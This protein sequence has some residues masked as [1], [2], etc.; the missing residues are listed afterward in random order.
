M[1]LFMKGDFTLN[2]GL[3]SPWKLECDAL[4]KADW[5]GLGAMIGPNI[6]FGLV[7][8]VPRGGF[9]FS[10][11][12]KPYRSNSEVV[13]LVDDVYTT[14]G[15]ITRYRDNHIVNGLGFNKKTVIGLVLFARNPIR[16]EH[17][18]WITPVFTLDPLF[19]TPTDKK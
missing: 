8:G 18:S 19:S 3:K 5:D 7:Y 11:A 2:S 6:E 14:G 1:N 16:E 12:L 13:L 17:Q 10:D 15:S 9:P 4:T